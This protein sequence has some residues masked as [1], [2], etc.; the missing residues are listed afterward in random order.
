ME[1]VRRIWAAIL[2][3]IFPPLCVSCRKY[4]DGDKWNF[5][6]DRCLE[7]IITERYPRIINGKNVSAV[8]DYRDPVIRQLIHCLKYRNMESI[9]KLLGEMLAERLKH[10]VI[11]AE[12][13]IIVPI[14]LHKRKERQRG[15]NQ[16]ELI[17]IVAGKSLCLP[18]AS[19]SILRIRP[20][21]PQSEIPDLK[22]KA[23]NV[24]G[25]FGPG[26]DIKAVLGKNVVIMDD[27]LTS[28]A[29]MAEVVKILK[30][31]GAKKCIR[32]VIAMAGRH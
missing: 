10:I 29:T 32:A 3:V 24:K 25:I 28:G 19:E 18:V 6:C 22:E 21:N 4:I 30:K 5:I 9:S 15:Y 11:E 12:S 20:N 2:D 16:A 26:P 13:T 27:I 8:A 14:P 31:G 1:T 23:A 17:A 7:K